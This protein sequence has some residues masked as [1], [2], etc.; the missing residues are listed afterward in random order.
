V[1]SGWR[2]HG[3]SR[4]AA[5]ERDGKGYCRQHDPEAVKAREAERNEEWAKRNRVSTA[6]WALD[7]ARDDLLATVRAADPAL[8]PAGLRSARDKLLAAEATLAEAQRS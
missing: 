8:L 1:F 7:S 6:K 5:V 4:K 2:D 3:C